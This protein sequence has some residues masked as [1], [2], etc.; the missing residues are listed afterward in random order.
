MSANTGGPVDPN[1]HVGHDEALDEVLLSTDT[2]GSLLTGDRRMGKT[3]LLR[4]VESL[5]CR[6]HVVLR[7]SAETGS[8][9]LFASRLLN[10]L[11]RTSAF[12]RELENW[13]VTVDVGYRG[14]RLQRT[15]TAKN[16]QA[17]PTDDL[18]S[19]AAKKAAPRKLIVIIDE[20]TV[21][22]QAIEKTNPG[23]ALELLRNLRRPRQELDNVAIVL[24]GSV[25]LHHAT[26]DFAPLNDLRKVRVGALEP[27]AGRYLVRCLLLG[28]GVQASDDRAVADAI[29]HQADGIAYYIHNL[30]ASARRRGGVLQP[31]TVSQLRQQAMEDPD[32]PW[33][34]RH[35]DRRIDDYYGGRSKLV[36]HIL[37][38][39]AT[40]SAPLTVT[41]MSAH[42]LAV[43]MSQR[44]S[45]DELLLLLEQLEADH[46]LLRIGGTD[47]FASTVIRDAWRSIRRLG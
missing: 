19:W 30:V 43:E 26:S 27:A 1:D 33:D 29:Y 16:Q 12:A 4:K 42:L 28:E 47:S 9:E 25:G 17:P 3:S 11:H 24:A 32:D 34:L 7:V 46:Y 15:P 20:I 44:P 5:L 37:D 14:F 6:D 41:D 40:A 23:G 45:R 21:L 10:T 36:R 22:A 18:F 39:Y 13:H 8:V 38:I 2:V 31:Q 35:Y